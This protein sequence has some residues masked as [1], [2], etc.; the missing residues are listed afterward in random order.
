[1]I[2]EIK[3]ELQGV[4][5]EI[6]NSKSRMEG[7]REFIKEAITMASEKYQID[8]KT[9]RK[10]AKAFHLQNINKEIE[11]MQEFMEKYETITGVKIDA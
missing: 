1:M 8:K 7:E 11:E 9:L 2:E 10:V 3:K 6:S 4:L 5:Q